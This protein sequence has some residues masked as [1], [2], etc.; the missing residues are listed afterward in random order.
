[1]ADSHTDTRSADEIERDIRATQR[2]M[3]RTVDQLENQ[4][5]PRNLL[6]AALDKADGSGIDSRYLLD[7]ARRNPLALGMIAIGGLWLVSDA[8]ARPSALKPSWG[9]SG[10]DN[11]DHDHH[12]DAYHRGYVAHMAAC[13]PRHGEDEITYRRRRD[14][15]RGSYLMLE[16]H[17]DEDESSYRQRLNDATDRMRERRDHMSEQAR[18][19]AQRAR[20]GAG[21]AAGAARG[22]YQDN[23]LVGGFAAAFVG[24]IAGSLLPVSRT[25]EDYLGGAGGRVLDEAQARAK[26]AGDMAREKKDELVEKADSSMSQGSGSADDGETTGYPHA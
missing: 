20:A 3:S 6:N 19:T 10:K 9:G 25:E 13:E 22:A 17:H 26:Q 11:G 15:A 18:E 7:C 2:D 24:A 23:P 14:A 1:M 12:G 5:T 8:D 16:Q 4:F 21:R